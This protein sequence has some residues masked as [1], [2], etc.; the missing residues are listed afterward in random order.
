MF[1]MKNES[2]ASENKNKKNNEDFL[3]K[4]DKDRNAKGC[5]YAI[6]VSMLELDNDLYDIGIVDKS[7]L[8]KKQTSNLIYI[9]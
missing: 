6:L 4:L 7:H 8:Y 1:D 9:I 5:E 3:K 2:I